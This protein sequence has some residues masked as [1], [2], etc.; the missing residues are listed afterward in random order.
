MAV[1]GEGMFGAELRK[2]IIGTRPGGQSG[3]IMARQG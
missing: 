1:W 3:A 2:A